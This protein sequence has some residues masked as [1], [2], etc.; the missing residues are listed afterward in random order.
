MMPQEQVALDAIDVKILDA[1]QTD[2][3]RSIGEI[4]AEVNLSHNACWR[5]IKLLEEADVI[6]GRVALLNA[7]RLGCGIT[8]FVSLTAG[9]HTDKW[10]ESFSERVKRMPEVVEFYRLTGD[11]DY[12]IKLQI[13]DIESYDQVYKDLI[14]TVKLRDVSAAFSMEELKHTHA[15]PLRASASSRGR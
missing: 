15:L 5:R 12:L 11:I 14:R 13:P 8:V 4:A 7:K 3:G 2:A 1:L 10:L 9:E 6:R